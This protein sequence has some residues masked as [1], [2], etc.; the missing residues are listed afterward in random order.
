M[1]RLLFPA[2]LKPGCYILPRFLRIVL[3]FSFF[4][5]CCDR[6]WRRQAAYA[7]LVFDGGG[8]G[9][10]PCLPSIA[11]LCRAQKL[12]C[13]CLTRI[14]AQQY[15]SHPDEP[16]DLAQAKHSNQNVQRRDDCDNAYRANH[17][18]EDIQSLGK[19]A[20]TEPG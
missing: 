7:F 1:P 16:D 20:S 12:V 18:P 11:A 8:E 14:A 3:L 13:R 19:S 6:F 9:L 17:Q 2:R 15:N 4:S 5:P 10:H